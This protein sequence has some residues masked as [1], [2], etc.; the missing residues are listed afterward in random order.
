MKGRL[1]PAYVNTPVAI[2]YAA[3]DTLHEGAEVARIVES[4]PRGV[5]VECPSNSYMHSAAVA[6]E[7]RRFEATL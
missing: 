7:L 6:D 2:A 5:A 1:A 3:S 4:L